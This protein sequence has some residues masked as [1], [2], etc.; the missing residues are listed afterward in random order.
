MSESGSVKFTHE[1]IASAPVAFRGMAELNACRRRL[2]QLRL[3]GVDTVGIGF[4]NLSVRASEPACFHITGSMTGALAELGP[5]HF[6]RV[7]AYDFSRNWLRSEG[8]AVASS[9]SLTHAAI[10]EADASVS[11]II[12]AHGATLWQRWSGV[13]PTTSPTV[14]Y[15]TPAMAGAVMR[16][17]AT[18]DVK[19]KKLFVMGGHEDG[20]VAFGGDLEEA[21]AVLVRACLSS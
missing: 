4:G 18:T 19:E 7:T 2:L 9:E 16:L 3:L 1:Q 6:A 11:G 14:E 10:Y 15:G 21:F 17:F 8:G 20:I 12:H 13:A 5:E